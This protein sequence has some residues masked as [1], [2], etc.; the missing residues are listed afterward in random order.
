VLED[1]TKLAE[2][3]VSTIEIAEGAD[4][5]AATSGWGASAGVVLEAVKNLPRG[6]PNPRLL[7]AARP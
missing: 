6:A 2:T 5:T 4:A 7:G 1:H 3:I